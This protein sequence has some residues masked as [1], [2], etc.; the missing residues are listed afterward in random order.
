MLRMTIL[1]SLPLHMFVLTVAE[2]WDKRGWTPLCLDVHKLKKLFSSAEVR[3]Q[4]RNPA[5]HTGDQRS[6]SEKSIQDLWWRE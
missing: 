3:S 1:H 2:N 4:Q 5:T 6:I